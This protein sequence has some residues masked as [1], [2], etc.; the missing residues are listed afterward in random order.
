[1]L[2]SA[3]KIL[4]K[5][6]MKLDIYEKERPVGIQIFGANLDP[7]LQAVDIVEKTKPDII[8]INYGSKKLWRA[9]CLHPKPNT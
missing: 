7:M 5:S 6:V 4:A 1:M 3:A 9:F 2:V 8:D